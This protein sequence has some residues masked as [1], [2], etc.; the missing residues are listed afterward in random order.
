MKYYTI[1]SERFNLRVNGQYATYPIYNNVTGK[2]E[3][4]LDCYATD[5][6]FH[7]DRLNGGVDA[8]FFRCEEY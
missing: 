6:K 1:K 5:V 8:G 4:N 2:K 7:L 3:Y